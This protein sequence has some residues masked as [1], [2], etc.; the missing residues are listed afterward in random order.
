MEVFD[1]SQS[2]RSRHG[3]EGVAGLFLMY[4]S[5][6]YAGWL[7]FYLLNSSEWEPMRTSL[8]IPASLS[9]QISRKSPL[10]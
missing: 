7:L 1:L 10:M 6:F 8:M 2:R 3:P 5:R 4:G 9:Y